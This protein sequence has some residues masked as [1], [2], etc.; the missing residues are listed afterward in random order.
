MDHSPRDS[1][2]NEMTYPEGMSM[3]EAQPATVSAH[4]WPPLTIGQ[5]K[6]V[7][8]W[9][10]SSAAFRERVMA[11]PERAGHE[12]KLGFNP[13]L[14]RPL[15]DDGYHKDPANEGR[16]THPV[17]EAYRAFF[18]KKTQWREQVKKEC[19]PDEPRFK[20][21]RARQIA[22]NAMENGQYDNGIIHAPFAIEL[23][24][25]CSVGCWFCGVGATKFVETWRYTE[26]NAALW[27]SVLKVM[28]AKIGAAARWGFC[29]WATDPLDNPD[30]EHFAGDFAD[31]T[32]MYPQTTTAQGHKD[33]ERVRKLLA[34]SESR[35]CLINRF[36]VLTEPLLRQIHA[37][38]TPDELTRVEIVAQM[39]DATVPKANAGAFRALAK[40]RGN[41]L[42]MEQRKL[43]Q[44][45]GATR[46]AAD[47]GQEPTTVTV[48]QPGTIACVSGFLMNM[49]KRSIKLISPCRASEKWPLGYI[50][51]EERT[52]TDAADLQRSIEEMMATHMPLELKPEDPIR[53]NPSF[54]LE[55]APNGF[56][57]MSPMTGVEFM[58]PDKA[59]FI[60]SIGQLVGSG[61]RTAGQIALSTLFQYGVPEVSTLGTLGAM[62]ELGLLVDAQGRIAGELPGGAR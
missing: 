31:I 21:W 7:L 53:I 45:A 47:A 30:Y 55:P 20:A 13:D 38:Y 33:P 51:F 62:F 15:W 6:R 34:V 39:R 58:R 24:D 37:E 16:P 54:R 46:A 10:S 41:V 57:V 12:Y 32:G 44:L 60:G 42:S 26:E 28:N 2:S 40:T 59:E 11:D 3:T 19:A 17:V 14:I 8:E 29:Y 35:G 18:R 43:A 4:A 25:G 36:S 1:Q 22:R 49:V 27:R 5:A 48:P 52:F 61:E 23:N 50:V 56:R 9:W